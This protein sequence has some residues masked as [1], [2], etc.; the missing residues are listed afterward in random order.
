MRSTTLSDGTQVSYPGLLA[1]AFSQ[2]PVAVKGGTPDASCMVS[3]ATSEGAMSETRT[4]DS[5]G[6]LFIDISRMAQLVF[7]EMG[8]GLDYDYGGPLGRAHCIKATLIVTVGGL[9]ATDDVWLQWG[10]MD[11]AGKEDFKRTFRLRHWGGYP[12][13][14]PVW[15]KAMN[16][17][18]PGVAGQD[19]DPI[20]LGTAET[21]GWVQAS[22]EFLENTNTQCEDVFENGGVIT[23]SHVPET[24]DVTNLMD[25]EYTIVPTCPPAGDTLYLRWLTRQGDIGYYLFGLSSTGASSAADLSYSRSVSGTLVPDSYGALPSSFR[26]DKKP[27]RTLKAGVELS[28]EYDFETVADLLQS[29]VVEMYHGGDSPWWERVNVTATTVSRDRRKG[30]KL[31]KVEITVELEPGR[32]VRSW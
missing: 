11:Y 3:L 18:G 12:W 26:R 24:E 1:F 19:G 32:A 23:V 14:M 21:S 27:G 5:D 6:G 31:Q 8:I 28:D 9:A 25:A 4:L 15:G 17:A 13:S 2:M 30:R 16:L 7:P 29:P 20:D 10:A 22:R